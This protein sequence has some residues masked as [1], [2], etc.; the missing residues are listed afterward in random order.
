VTDTTP[1]ADRVH[2]EQL[3]LDACIGVTEDERSKRQRLV[4]NITVYPQLTFDRLGDDID[5][6]VNYVALCRSARELVEGREWN[7]IETVASELASHL[8]AT[9]GLTST[10]VEVRKFVLP[11]TRYV[12]ATALRRRTA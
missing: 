6:A 12:S 5:K 2:L 1:S 4:L 8:L 9:F 3:E 10:E 11:Q 7:L